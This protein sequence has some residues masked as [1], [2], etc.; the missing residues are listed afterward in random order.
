MKI[1]FTFVLFLVLWSGRPGFTREIDVFEVKE[2]DDFRKK[3]VFQKY[4]NWKYFCRNDCEKENILIKTFSNEEDNGRYRIEFKKRFFDPS[5]M[6]V[7]IRNV[8]LSDTGTYSC[9]LETWH[10][11]KLVYL[12]VDFI[13][14]V[15]SVVRSNHSPGVLS[16]ETHSE[17]HEDHTPLSKVALYVGLSLSALLILSVTLTS[18]ILY[19]RKRA[20]TT[21]GAPDI[22][23]YAQ[24]Q[25]MAD[26]SSTLTYT[27]VDFSKHSSAPWCPT[28]TTEE[29]PVYSTLCL[30]HSE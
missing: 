23:V 9:G 7:S 28:A 14:N 22:P 5:E 27:Q 16:P 8:T 2:G 19:R 25:E 15:S 4:G 20:R 12:H 29:A 10:E 30:P 3:Y 13:I 1:A 24:I 21:P 6:Y 26:S 18:L 17:P 11:Y